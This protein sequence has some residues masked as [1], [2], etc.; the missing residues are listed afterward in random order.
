MRLKLNAKQIEQLLPYFDRVRASA[1]MGS[2]GML[3]G[4]IGWNEDGEYAITV[5]FLDNDKAQIVTEAGRS[6]IPPALGP[7]KIVPHATNG[8]PPDIAPD[9]PAPSPMRLEKR[10]EPQSAE[11]LP[12]SPG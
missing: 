4:Q 7:R 12:D 10:R 8:R 3:V 2:P 1:A 6:D 11:T 9:P 5:A